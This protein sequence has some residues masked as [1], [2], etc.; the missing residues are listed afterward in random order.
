MEYMFPNVGKSKKF[1]SR[2]EFMEFN[3][4][5]NSFFEQNFADK[6]HYI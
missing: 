2:N 6:I 4:F 5:V 3:K 1:C